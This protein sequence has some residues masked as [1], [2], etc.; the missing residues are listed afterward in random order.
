MYAAT[1]LAPHERGRFLDDACGPDD[2][3]RREV[4]S[5]LLAEKFEVPE[6]LGSFGFV[7][8][9]DDIVAAFDRIR[10]LSSH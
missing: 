7:E 3:L 4:E 8:G 2:A 1:L 6:R 9:S 10:V 5:M